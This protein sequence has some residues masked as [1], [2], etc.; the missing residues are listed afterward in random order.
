MGPQSDLD[1][2]SDDDDVRDVSE[3]AR[4]S[5]GILTKKKENSN[6]SGQSHSKLASKTSP[7]STKQENKSKVAS[8]NSKDNIFILEGL[9]GNDLTQTRTHSNAISCVSPTQTDPPPYPGNDTTP[10]T[11][12]PLPPKANSSSVP[13]SSSIPNSSPNEEILNTNPGAKRPLEASF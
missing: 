3:A 10:D 13:F 6:S 2:D 1:E 8:R 4:I 12:P 7:N 11:T 9:K 5:T